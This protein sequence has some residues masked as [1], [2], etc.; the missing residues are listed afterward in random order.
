MDAVGRA[1]RSSTEFP[2]ALPI[3][4]TS[5]LAASAAAASAAFKLALNR[6]KGLKIEIGSSGTSALGISRP[7][8]SAAAPLRTD[9][10]EPVSRRAGMSTP[11][12]R[13]FTENKPLSDSCSAGTSHKPANTS[14]SSPSVSP[15]SDIDGPM[16]APSPQRISNP[17]GNESKKVEPS[18]PAAPGDVT[19]RALAVNP[20]MNGC[21]S[22]FGRSANSTVPRLNVVPPVIAPPVPTPPGA[23]P[24]ASRPNSLA[25]SALI[26]FVFAAVSTIMSRSIPDALRAC[27]AG[28]PSSGKESASA[29]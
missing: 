16:S 23:S 11:F 25:T 19:G 15:K 4:T 20:P 21:R 10:G 9:M 14:F 22:A 2:P 29:G 12:T 13:S 7:A 26:T 5:P 6:A 3:L 18:S 8:A 17:P 27:C 28:V 1:L 24:I